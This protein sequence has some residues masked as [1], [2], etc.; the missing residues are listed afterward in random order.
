M[1][2]TYNYCLVL[3]SVLVAVIVSHTALR[4]AAR[5]GR[6]GSGS[7]H[8]WLTGGA[9][10]LGT[11]MWSM[12]FIGMLAFSLPIPMS[13]GLG[14]T[15]G[16]L[17]LAVANSG[18]ALWIAGHSRTS[19][20]RLACGALILG[21][22]I[23]GTHYLGMTSLQIVPMISYEPGLVAASIAIAVVAS[24]AALWLFVNLGEG[25]TLKMRA[26]RLGAALGMGAAISGMHYVGM[27]A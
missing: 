4:L 19:G 14:A 17:L 26:A 6:A 15:I 12:H 3:L 16:S 1:T 10:A 8:L 2:G 13:Y 20:L 7:A 24:F 11:G 18:F 9:I 21:A 22:G 25:G 27:A 23:S 5:I